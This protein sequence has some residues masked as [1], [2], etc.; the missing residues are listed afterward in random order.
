MLRILGSWW[1]LTLT[2][3]MKWKSTG[4]RVWGTR[5]GER[6]GVGDMLFY[7][8]ICPL[9]SFTHRS[10]PSH[11]QIFLQDVDQWSMDN[12]VDSIVYT[13]QKL[14]ESFTAITIATL[15]GPL[16]AIAI[17]LRCCFRR[18]S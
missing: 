1:G 15:L 13:D 2:R 3:E 7:R 4:Y 17:A 8:L 10:L 9:I 16:I 18:G 6:E 14:T 11:F 12:L 5:Y